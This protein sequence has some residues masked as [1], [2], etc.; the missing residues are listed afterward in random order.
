MEYPLAIVELRGMLILRFEE[1]L[2]LL[3]LLFMLNY[4]KL[5]FKELGSM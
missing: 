2:G 4:S 1:D 3:L 5:R